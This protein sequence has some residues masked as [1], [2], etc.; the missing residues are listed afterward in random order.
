MQL[1]HL[2]I[3]GAFHHPPPRRLKHSYKQASEFLVMTK[4]ST[5]AE[6]PS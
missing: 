3:K 6:I 4:A 5:K 2:E 1:D